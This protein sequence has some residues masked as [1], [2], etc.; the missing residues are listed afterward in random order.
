[1]KYTYDDFADMRTKAALRVMSLFFVGMIIIAATTSPIAT[2]TKEGERAPPLSRVNSTTV[3][4]GVLSTVNP[5]GIQT[6]KKV[7][8]PVN[9]LLWNSWT[10]TAHTVFVRLRMY[11][12]ILKTSVEETLNGMEQ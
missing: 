6:G 5:T 9:G 2:G 11:L 4:D 8:S 7:T 3:P 12:K 1:M 10:P